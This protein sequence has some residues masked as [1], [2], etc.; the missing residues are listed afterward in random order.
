MSGLES[1]ANYDREGARRWRG[2]SILFCIAACGLALA[3]SV[4]WGFF[5]FECE[6]ACDPSVF[7]ATSIPFAIVAWAM[8][9]AFAFTLRDATLGARERNS[10]G[11]TLLLATGAWLL[12]LVLVALAWR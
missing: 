10:I 6:P 7:R 1:S 3:A 5:V 8:W 12:A 2:L 11:M 9:S 4:V